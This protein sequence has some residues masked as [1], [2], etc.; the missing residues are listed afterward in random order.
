MQE[1]KNIAVNYIFKYSFFQH[2]HTHTLSLPKVKSFIS[3]R[4]WDVHLSRCLHEIMYS[5]FG[6]FN[7]K[8]CYF[9]SIETDQFHIFPRNFVSSNIRDG[10]L[11]FVSTFRSSFRDIR[12]SFSNYFT[13]KN[14]IFPGARYNV[15]GNP[16]FI[17]SWRTHDASTCPVA[18]RKAIL[19]VWRLHRERYANQITRLATRWLITRISL[20]NVTCIMCESRNNIPTPVKDLFGVIFRIFYVMQFFIYLSFFDI[21]IAFLDCIDYWTVSWCVW[22]ERTNKIV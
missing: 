18:L 10:R 4:P 3:R 17:Y 14:R 5:D 15:P 6:S 2:T 13:M 1:R 20:R 21:L 16:H 7:N 12:H 8:I 11:Q 9:P 19:H 22:L